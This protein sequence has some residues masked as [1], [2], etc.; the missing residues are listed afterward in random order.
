METTM[1]LAIRKAVTVDASVERAFEVFTRQIESW[2]PVETHSIAGMRGARPQELHLELREGG[3]L[4]E[5][6]EGEEHSWGRVLVYDPPN[7]ITLEWHV[8]PFNPPT[9]VDVTF[10]AEGAGTRVELV[11]SGWERF[12]DPD[13][14]TRASYG[15]QDGWTGVL[16]RYVERANAE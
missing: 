8:N 11:H 3:R 13:Q 12:A 14:K 7:R 1:D 9:E 16:A 5:V 10:T 6:T 4:Y 2:W 15:S